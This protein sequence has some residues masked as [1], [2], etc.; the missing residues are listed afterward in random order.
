MMKLKV[1]IASLAFIFTSNLFAHFQMVYSKD[2]TLEMSKKVD[3]NIVFTHPFSGAYIMNMSG[4]DAFYVINKNKK[5]D[6]KEKL[7]QVTYT[8]INNSGIGY[9][10]KYSARR[11]GDHLFVLQPQLF[12]DETTKSYTQQITKLIMN[13]TGIPTDWDRDLGLKAEI[14]PLT[15]PY[16]IWAGSNFTGIAKSK[17]KAV[18]Y[19]TIEVKYLNRTFN[20]KTNTLGQPQIKAPQDSFANMTLKANKDGE[21]TFTIPKEG[22]WGFKA[23]NIGSD[24]T[25]KGEKLEQ[26]GVIW[27][28]A[29]KME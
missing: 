28:Q 8:D 25:Y 3:I 2:L 5:Q 20:T 21:F 1:I 10:F 7:Q 19:A 15:K 9:H 11:M 18:P 24:K 14:V 26:D 29:T 13:V 27:V 4:I 16:A 23:V 17:G 22:F 6:L 12:Y